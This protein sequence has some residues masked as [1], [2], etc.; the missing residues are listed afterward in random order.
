[1]A[2]RRFDPLTY[3]RVLG[4]DPLTCGPGLLSRTR[5]QANAS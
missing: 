1:L 5:R 4:A 3:E 2:S